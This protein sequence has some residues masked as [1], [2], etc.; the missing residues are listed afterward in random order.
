MALH[1]DEIFHSG[2]TNIEE[3]ASENFLEIGNQA[4]KL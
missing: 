4:E 1:R 2:E 3:P